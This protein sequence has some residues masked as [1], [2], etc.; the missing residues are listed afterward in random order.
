MHWTVL[1]SPSPA[2]TGREDILQKM[3]QA[4]FPEATLEAAASRRVFMQHG[5]GG[6]GNTQICC[7]LWERHRKRSVSFIP[8]ALFGMGMT[9]TDFGGCSRST[10]ETEKPSKPAFAT[11]SEPLTRAQKPPRVIYRDVVMI[12]YS[13]WV[14]RTTPTYELRISAVRRS[15][16]NNS[17]NPESG[18]S[19][20]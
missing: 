1:R 13:S 5:L 17:H 7:K 11:S 4:L 14:A 19:G 18:Q 10:G 6:S 20:C 12:D 8:K 16:N 15:G 2:F 3:E 9:V